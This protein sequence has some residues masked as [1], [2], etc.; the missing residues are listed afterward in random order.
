[1]MQRSTVVH[2]NGHLN[3]DSSQGTAINHSVPAA[4]AWPPTTTRMHQRAGR[5]PPPAPQV[6]CKSVILTAARGPPLNEAP[7]ERKRREAREKK[8][9]KADVEEP[10]PAPAAPPPS[11]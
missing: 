10:G 1:M 9:K 8:G 6:D 11:S 4:A 3:V 7:W 5:S 2:N